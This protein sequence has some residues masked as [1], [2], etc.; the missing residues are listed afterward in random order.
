MNPV[1]LYTLGHGE[2]TIDSLIV[3]LRQARI[4]VVVDIRTEAAAERHPQFSGKALRQAVER[5]G[6]TY[7][8]AGRQLGDAR[9]VRAGSRHLSLADAELRGFADYMDTESFRRAAS[10]LVNMARKA[11]TAILGAVRDPV[12]CHRSLIAD[13][14]LLSG[15]H[16]M[17]LIEPHDQR[18]HALRTE[19]R[20]ESTDLVYDRRA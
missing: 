17:H 18:E 1:T 4:A 5:A 3:V 7:H 12:H 2:R 8:W 13:Y 15:V 6:M 10:Q 9:P 11:P 20:R 14:L 19:A 16:V